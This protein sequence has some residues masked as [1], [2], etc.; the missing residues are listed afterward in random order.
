MS[1][2]ERTERELRDFA[3]LQVRAG[4]LTP[5]QQYDE[6]R[7]AVTAEMP[8][9]DA[10]ILT[11]AW[12]AAAR[13]ELDRL[14]ATWEPV[15]DHDRLEGAFAEC[16]EHGVPVLQGVE[17]DVAQR[18]L[19]E[20]DPKPRGLVWFTEADVWHAVDQDVLV[21]T[22]TPGG[23]LTGAVASCFERHG[24]AVRHAAGRVEVAARWQRR[25]D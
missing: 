21:V 16:A 7:G 4:L 1:H 14:A 2:S 17:G 20:C 15:T 19:A 13:Q 23:E 8:H 24:L 25:A 5:A 10:A 3:R 6:V 9:T 22:V 18:H 12:L 11:R